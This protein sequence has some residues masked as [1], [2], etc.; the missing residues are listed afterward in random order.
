LEQTWKGLKGRDMGG[1]RKKKHG[2]GWTEE[3]RE[4]LREE[5]YGRARRKRH[6]RG[7]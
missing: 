4:G 2:R 1:V 6:E 3:T 7:S 5:R